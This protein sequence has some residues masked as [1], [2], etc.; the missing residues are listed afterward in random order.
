MGDKRLALEASEDLLELLED[1]IFLRGSIGCLPAPTQQ[2]LRHRI[3]L[4][5]VILKGCDTHAR[6]R[7]ALASALRSAEFP[8]QHLGVSCNRYV[9]HPPV[10]HPEP[11]AFATHALLAR[12]VE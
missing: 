10:L 4:L 8:A 6:R 11:R 2:G 9:V 3:V 12:P 5:L 7:V 1:A